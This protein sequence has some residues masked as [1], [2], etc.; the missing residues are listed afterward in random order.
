M[1]FSHVYQKD[2][3]SITLLSQ[4]C[5]FAKGFHC[6]NSGQEVQRVRSNLQLC[7]LHDLLQHC[8][9]SSS[10]NNPRKQQRDRLNQEDR[11]DSPSCDPAAAW[12]RDAWQGLRVQ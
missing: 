9:G 10:G 4:G 6:E 3:P 7:S 2:G 5:I 8:E 12:L 11:P 1:G